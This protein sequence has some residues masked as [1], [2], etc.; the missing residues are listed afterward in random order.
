MASQTFS[1]PPAPFS[2][3]VCQNGTHKQKEGP[4]C[5][6]CPSFKNSHWFPTP[7]GE[8][9]PDV[10]F[11]G[12]HPLKP[13]LSV[14][15]NT[16]SHNTFDD[17]AGKIVLGAVEQLKRTAQYTGLK[18]RYAYAVKCGI[19]DPKGKQIEACSTPLHAELGK[20]FAARA[21]E[22][23]TQPLV[24]VAH[25]MV[26]LRALNVR[27]GKFDEAA[28]RVFNVVINNTP[29]VVVPTMGMKAIVG[30]AGKYSSIQEDI[31]RAFRAA[32]NKTA[33]V[34]DKSV[35][36]SGYQYP[37]TNAELTALVDYIIAYSER[38]IPPEDWAISL[39]TETNT[40]FPYRD[41][42]ILTV[43]SVSWADGKSA[44]IPLWHPMLH[45]G[46]DR[47]EQT[48]Q[49]KVPPMV[50]DSYDPD[51]AW[52]DVK[53][54]I[55]SNKKKIFHNAGYDLKV[56]WKIGSE[57]K[58]LYWDVMLAEHA[59]EEDKKGQ[60]R[61][62]FLT[63]Q[64]L[65]EY[66]GYEDQLQEH[67]QVE[68]GDNQLDNVH[69]LGKHNASK[70]SDVPQAIADAVT[71]LGYTFEEFSSHK[72]KTLNKTLTGLQQKEALADADTSVIA[73]LRL[74]I[75]SIESG[76]FKRKVTKQEKKSGGF[77]NIPLHDLLFYAAVDADVTRRLAVKQVQ[78]MAEEDLALAKK[79][80]EV[81]RI[82]EMEMRRN[83][84]VFQVPRR[85]TAPAPIKRLVNNFY[86]PRCEMLAKVEYGGVSVDRDY[87]VKAAGELG[88]VAERLKGELFNLAGE[89]FKEG[90][91]KKIAYYLFNTGL[92]FRHPD[93]ERA[94]EL[95]ASF[96]DKLAWNG[97][98]MTYKGVSWT[99]SGA[100]QT[101]EKVLR[102][103]ATQYD[104]PFSNTIL[105]LRKSLKAK[106]TFLEN[107][108]ALSTFDGRLHTSY[109]ITGTAT[110]RLSSSA[111]N[112]QNVPK[113]YVGGILDSYGKPKLGLDG[114]PI[115]KGVNCKK[116]FIPDNSDMVFVNCDAKG[117][118]VSI[119]A[120]YSLDPDLL[121]AMEEG[122]DAHSFFSSKILDPEFVTKGLTGSSR[123]QRLK[124]VGID[125]DHAWS[126]EDFK[127]RDLLS[128]SED[129]NVVAY[130]KRLKK[131]RDLIKR[132]VFGLLFGAGYR[133]IAELVGIEES[134]A[135]DVVNL[136]F[137]KFPT[138]KRFMDYAKWEGRIF[139]FV[140]TFDGRRRR[141]LMTNAPKEMLARAE[142]QFVNFLI[143]GSNSDVVLQT[144][145][146]MAPVIERDFG[147]RMLLTV[148]D[149][150]GFQIQKKYL[151]Q[152]KDFVL[153]YGTR[154]VAR[155]C[156]HWLP[157]P[158]RWDIEVGDSYGEL[159]SVDK[160]MANMA[161]DVNELEHGGY[162]FDEMLTAFEEDFAVL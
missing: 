35:L 59:L 107:A 148:H 109:N 62:K 38:G 41:G 17:V 3:G 65:P 83:A 10:L 93:P 8:K 58:N 15:G 64:F 132:V 142:R 24:I 45:D 111:M 49:W 90:N 137:T 11:L 92:G 6:A 28:G 23:K 39:D 106:N 66:A 60:Y 57:V 53:R 127:N 160:Y 85:N 139:G 76:D 130:G 131:L 9:A 128:E 133:K 156:G 46:R 144:M 55:T 147:G 95:A 25:G 12:D 150:V 115:F 42:L 67:L 100:L 73:D 153:E 91:A 80:A 149:S 40:L 105:N 47:D 125:A 50:D 19:D 161:D 51:A 118:E 116:V 5:T 121:K 20:I 77:E 74:V 48:G 138:L 54:L 79:K 82:V 27:V 145:V 113:D 26:A 16:V 88:I 21:A 86:V 101:T 29:V 61:L 2:C 68:E 120:A 152:L 124:D 69:K 52:L 4:S 129:P 155:E 96:P 36:E 122:L 89:E 97:S 117:A 114:K 158:F 99:E 34:V 143:Q 102:R 135:K 13:R 18:T 123:H 94:V 119:F 136:F 126:Y 141:F 112:M 43:V 63:K 98:R 134:L 140:E 33:A 110:S 162:T 70:V 44:A 103:L 75:A 104:C 87:A 22:N 157:V 159:M 72:K 84:D 151:G 7:L 154:R 56:F 78:R 81:G 14:I 37:R 30:A 31:A 1:A 108:L 146:A 32:T 71:R